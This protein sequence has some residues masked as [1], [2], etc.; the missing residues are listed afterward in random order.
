MQQHQNSKQ[1]NWDQKSHDSHMKS[2]ETV[3]PQNQTNFLIK[4]NGGNYEAR[5]T[6]SEGSLDLLR[7]L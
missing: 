2:N 3:F 6:F 5:S 7:F 4:S 1:K